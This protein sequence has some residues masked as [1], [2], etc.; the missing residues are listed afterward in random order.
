MNA[1]GTG[2]ANLTPGTPTTPDTNPRYSA[3]GRH[4]YWIHGSE[5]WVMTREGTQQHLLFDLG[6]IET[7]F[8]VAPVPPWREVVW[9]VGNEVRTADLDGSNQRVLFY[10]SNDVYFPDISPDG[11]K[12]AYAREL[13]DEI[14]VVS[15]AGRTCVSTP[16]FSYGMAWSRDSAT[17]YYTANEGDGQIWKID[18]GTASPTATLFYD[19]PARRSFGLC[20]AHDSSALFIVEDPQFWTYNNY[21]SRYALPSGPAT[22]IAP[23]DGIRDF[24]PDCSPTADEIVWCKTDE[25]DRCNIWRMNADGTGAV[26]LTPGTPTTPDTNP[27]YSADGRHLYWIH[28]S[29]LWVMTREG[30]QQHLLFDLGE[31]ETHFDVAARNADVDADGV[32]CVADN[33]PALANTDQADFDED[34]VGDA[35]DNCMDAA[36]PDQGRAVFGQS[37]RALD[38]TTFVWPRRADIRWARGPLSAVG[39][40]SVDVV[41]EATGAD[42]I[43]DSATPNVGGAFF[44]L[45]RPSCS[46]GS[47]QSTL[48]D[49][50]GR[51]AILP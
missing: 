26:N 19:T 5:L 46:A 25:S 38:A 31:I 49:E 27:R 30:T 3:D 22:T 39:S 36:N 41:D 29:E 14:C 28:G 18:L 2:A 1:D 48:G 47:W 43:V 8:D 42:R 7:H 44:Y 4:L 33:C 16:G 37:V 50:P 24:F 9:T 11:A 12:L 17:I 21:V 15:A 10:E 35:C 45:V 6:E 20:E 32:L 13:G 23:G 34:S 40:Y 51:D